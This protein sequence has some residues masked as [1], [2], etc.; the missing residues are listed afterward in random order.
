MLYIYT[1]TVFYWSK[2]CF[3]SETIHS[4][5]VDLNRGTNGAAHAFDAME[6]VTTR[7]IDLWSEKIYHWCSKM[8]HIHPLQLFF[9]GCLTS[10]FENME[11]ILLPQT[12][13]W[14]PSGAAEVLRFLN[15]VS[16]VVSS[17]SPEGTSWDLDW[18]LGAK[19]QKMVPWVVE[20]MCL[21][22][23]IL[24]VCCIHIHCARREGLGISHGRAQPSTAEYSRAAEHST[25][26][27]TWCI[28]INVFHPLIHLRFMPPFNILHLCKPASTL[29]LL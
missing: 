8:S 24:Y 14:P 13:A 5:W 26:I 18:W 15:R 11:S 28:K 2:P 27:C 10:I 19:G 16:S 9:L 4:A 6:N 25:C 20:H 29:D 23:Y 7:F 22:M 3:C 1:V 17:Q 21:Y 12:A